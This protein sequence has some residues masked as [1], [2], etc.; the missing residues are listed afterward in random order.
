M[1]ARLSPDDANDSSLPGAESCDACPGRSD[2]S[3]FGDAC[4]RFAQGSKA[5]LENSDA[6]PRTAVPRAQVPFGLSYA[7]R[8]LRIG[9]RG[10]VAE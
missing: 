3:P 8:R 4:L 2:T 5:A 6:P 9:E 10:S 1:S 7:L